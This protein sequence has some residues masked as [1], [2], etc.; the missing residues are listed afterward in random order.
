[1]KRLKLRA[2]PHRDYVWDYVWTENSKLGLFVG[3]LIALEL[4]EDA[5]GMILPARSRLDSCVFRVI[6][7]D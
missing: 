4:R 2:I 5:H 3:A 1:V 6:S 7:G